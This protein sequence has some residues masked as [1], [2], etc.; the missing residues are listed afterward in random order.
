MRYS[1][2]LTLLLFTITLNAQTATEWQI[3]EGKEGTIPFNSSY[4]G[5]DRAYT[6]ARIPAANDA[7]WTKAP[8]DANG[9]VNVDRGS[10][11]DCLKQIDFLYFQT[12]VDIPENV[13]IK[14][15]TISYDKA[16]DGARIYFFNSK[17]PR[18]RFNATADLSQRNPNPSSVDL[19]NEIVAGETNRVVIVQ[20]DDCANR[21][22][23]QGIRMK[24]NG[25]EIKT[26]AVTDACGNEYTTVTYGEQVWL[27]E[28]LQAPACSACGNIAKTTLGNHP[29]KNKHF[30]VNDKPQYAFYGNNADDKDP[31]TG[32]PLGALFNYA[33]IKSCDVCP[34]GFRIPTKADWE[35]LMANV[36]NKRQLASRD[37]QD[38]NNPFMYMA[39][40]ADAYGSVVRGRFVQYWTSDSDPG[41][42]QKAQAFYLDGNG[43]AKVG[44][45]DKRLGLYVRCVKSVAPAIPQRFKLHAYSI[46]GDRN[47]ADHWMGR[48]KGKSEVDILQKVGSNNEI[49]Q[50][51]RVVVN[52]AADM[53]Y[54]E[55]ENASGGN[56]PYYLTVDPAARHR[57]KIMAGKSDWAKFYVRPALQTESPNSNYVSFESVKEPNSYLRHQG[58]RMYLHEATPANRSNKIF[59]EDASWMFQEIGK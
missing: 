56:G 8:T 38:G 43:Q 24:L 18:G 42:P 55:V 16:D 17:Y 6:K 48:T 11:V 30:Y 36:P 32:R 34:D 14:T 12:Q 3:H 7:G 53:V 21:N 2:T 9:A 28:N 26:D 58:F 29:S 22:S 45:E 39:G 44:P 52:G 59:I 46:S 13:D 37:A 47:N 50:I 23:I 19:K 25:E 35:T 4:H 27:R 31:Q 1:I 51:R 57:L 5:D 54:L 10:T 49:L 41:N 40:R 15:F 20:F 33:A